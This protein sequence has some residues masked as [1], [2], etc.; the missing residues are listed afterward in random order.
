MRK[1][2]LVTCVGIGSTLGLLAALGV[3]SLLE[4]AGAAYGPSAKY[5][6]TLTGAKEVPGPGDPDG[7]GVAA[8]KIKAKKSSVCVVIKKVV[9]IDLPSTG[10][11]IH[12]APAGVQGPT[13][14]FFAPPMAKKPGKPAKSKACATASTALL[15]RMLSYPSDFYVNVHTGA[16]PDGAIR[17]QLG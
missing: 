5:E 3:A 17:G 8:V 10:A 13:R 2:A 7:R 12:E 11:H 1:R 9:N 16:Y 14:L 15:N 6:T 4:P